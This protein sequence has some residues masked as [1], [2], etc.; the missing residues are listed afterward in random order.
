MFYKYGI[1]SAVYV[2]L[3]HHSI[4]SLDKLSVRIHF[5]ETFRLLTHNETGYITFYEKF[6]QVV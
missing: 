2:L 6:L 5:W 3:A 4:N 1:S